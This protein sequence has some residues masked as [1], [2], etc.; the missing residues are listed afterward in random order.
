[1]VFARRGGECEVC[2]HERCPLPV[3][4]RS[5]REGRRFLR[6]CF[7]DWDLLDM[8]DDTAL[9]LSELMSNALRH[10]RPPVIASVSCADQMIEVAVHDGSATLPSMRAH[11]SDLDGDLSRVLATE[12]TI[13]E[14]LDDRDPRLFIG[15]AGAVSGGRGL[16]L[17]DALAQEW[18][19]SSLPAGKWV[20]LRNPAPEDWSYGIGCPCSTSRAAITL[21]SGRSA[22]HRGE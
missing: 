19:V 4:P 21:A 13:G 17:I 16:L 15:A 7:T 6:R 22:V 2:R 20:W 3:E 8:L 9:A 14:V 18:G 12:A 10:A 11:R 5:V 1:M